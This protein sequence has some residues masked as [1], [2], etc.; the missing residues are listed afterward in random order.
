MRASFEPGPGT[1]CDHRPSSAGRP[2]TV[3]KSVIGHPVCFREGPTEHPTAPHPHPAACPGSQL[4]TSCSQPPLWVGRCTLSGHSRRPVPTR[5]HHL[6]L[7]V[8]VSVSRY[9]FFIR[10]PIT[11]DKGPPND[12]VC[13][14]SPAKT[15]FPNKV[16]FEG[17]G[18]QDFVF[19]RHIQPL[20]TPLKDHKPYPA[21]SMCLGWPLLLC[22]MCYL[23]LLLAC[24][25][26]L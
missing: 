3:F 11:L 6:P 15:L 7:C 18:A 21:S 19:G 10:T 20:T 26:A 12:L 25:R 13:T 23:T 16:T 9:P 22:P 1:V 24:S 8:S 5:P 17:R 2:P 14:G 4:F